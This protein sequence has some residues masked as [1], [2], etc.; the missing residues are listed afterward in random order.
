MELYFAIDR[1]APDVASQPKVDLHHWR[2]LQLG[3]GSL[4]I[5]AQLDSG[6]FR[7]TTALLAVDI[8][9]RVVKT[10]SGRSYHLDA[11]PEEDAMLVALMIANVACDP[12]A[13]TNDV[14]DAVWRAMESSAWSSDGTSLIP[15]L[16]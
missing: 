11:P 6:S 14:S 4:H 15:A 16:Q 8:A 10:E 2:I 1:P 13:I 3:C 5:A 12:V 7:V 9:S